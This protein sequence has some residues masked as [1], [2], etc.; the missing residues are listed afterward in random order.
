LLT[1]GT[2]VKNDVAM[3]TGLIPYRK[4]LPAAEKA[5]VKWYFIEDESP[6]SVEQIPQSVRYL[7]EVK[8]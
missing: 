6:S 7:K 1:G 5:G 4:I 3:G 2:D 8:W